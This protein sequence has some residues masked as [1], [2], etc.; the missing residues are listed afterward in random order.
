[1]P[2]ESAPQP[3]TSQGADDDAR[4]LSEFLST[5]DVPCPGCG[6]NLRHLASP[7]CPE[8]AEQIRL[9]VHLAEPKQGLLIAG[10][11]GLSAGAGLSGLLIL[12]A[13]IV[14]FTNDF[15]SYGRFL[16]VN[17]AGFLVFGAAMFLW[18]LHWRRLR[19]MNTRVRSGFVTAIWIS[20]LTFLVLFTIYIN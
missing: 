11:I 4:L 16:I 17:A 19:R 10:L 18:L 2:T 14:S 5:R 20:V 13:L 15:G 7:R 3:S 12:Y 1:M 9:G 6:Y 8:C